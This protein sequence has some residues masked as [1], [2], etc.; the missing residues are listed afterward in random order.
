MMPPLPPP[1]LYTASS[2]TLNHSSTQP[3]PL[4]SYVLD[5][6]RSVSAEVE[7]LPAEVPAQLLYSEA[8]SAKLAQRELG[9]NLTGSVAQL[10]GPDGQLVKGALSSVARCKPEPLITQLTT[11]VGGCG[12]GCAR[13]HA[14]RAEAAYV[15][16]VTR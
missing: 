9:V 13:V 4:R 6:L 11:E 5:T 10:L 3:C 12:C 14:W 8:D 16:R 1:L 15:P 7:L 2:S